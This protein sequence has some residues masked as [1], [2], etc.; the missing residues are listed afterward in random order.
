MKVIGIEVV[1]AGRK[2]ARII[3]VFQDAE[4]KIAQASI[5]LS[6]LKFV[7]ING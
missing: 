6:K 5:P 1:D 7:R 3:V 4:G 2:F